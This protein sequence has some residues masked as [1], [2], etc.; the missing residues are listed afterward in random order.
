M[1]SVKTL[2]MG[3]VNSET[4]QFTEWARDPN[5]NGD[6]GF[7]TYGKARTDNDKRL[8]DKEKN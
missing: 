5:I 3:S 2:F 8:D 6:G 1:R 7:Q 4:D